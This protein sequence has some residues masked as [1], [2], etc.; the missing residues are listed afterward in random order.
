M[1]DRS[2]TTAFTVDQTPEQ[3]FAAVTNVRGWW[4]QDIVGRTE[5][6]GDVFDYRYQD[7]HRCKIKVTESVPGKRVAWHVLENYFSF[8]KDPTEWTGTDMF[9]DISKKGGKTEIRLTH[10]GLVPEE[11]CYEACNQGW[12]TYI[13]SS[14]RDLITKGRGQPNVG[15][16]MTEKERALTA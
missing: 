3:V 7:V 14:L 11:E 8:T 13:N 9:F 6:A 15:E 4:S 1:D 10:R 2:F 16:P 5:K 12:T